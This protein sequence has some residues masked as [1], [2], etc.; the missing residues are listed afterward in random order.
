MNEDHTLVF[1]LNI[2]VMECANSD[3]AAFGLYAN[4]YF[5]EKIT[6]N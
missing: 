2:P 6:K 3:K 5:T 1:E 4:L